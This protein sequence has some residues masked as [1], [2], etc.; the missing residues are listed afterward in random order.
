MTGD[1][2]HLEDMG[3]LVSSLKQR[4]YLTDRADEFAQR[5][6]K[7]EPLPATFNAYDFNRP[8]PSKEAFERAA[9]QLNI[10]PINLNSQLTHLLEFVCEND[11][12]ADMFKKLLT[13]YKMCDFPKEKITNY[14]LRT[15]RDRLEKRRVEVTARNTERLE[16]FKLTN[17]AYRNQL[18]TNKEQIEARRNKLV[19][20]MNKAIIT[21]GGD[22]N[23]SPADRAAFEVL[24]KYG[25]VDWDGQYQ[26]CRARDIEL[27]DV[28]DLADIIIEVIKAIQPFKQKKKEQ[29]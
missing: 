10:D 17:H 18:A 28:L 11:Q 2:I 26:Q 5:S 14:R 20:S 23:L 25:L 16:K 24:E 9:E 27:I 13:Y 7:P 21:A 3:K 29:E 22:K 8:I 1:Y 19:R 15:E 12:A 6:V 4:H